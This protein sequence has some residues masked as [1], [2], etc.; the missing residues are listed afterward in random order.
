MTLPTIVFVPDAWHTPEYYNHVISILEAK[1]YPTVHVNLLLRAVF[2]PW[3]MM[4]Q[5]S[6]G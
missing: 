3:E 1:G 4:L 2:H 5:L 6:G